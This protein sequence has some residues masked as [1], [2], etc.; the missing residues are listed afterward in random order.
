MNTSEI[1]VLLQMVTGLHLDTEAVTTIEK[2]TEGWTV[3]VQLAALSLRNARDPRS[4]LQAFRGNHRFVLDY[5]SEEVFLQQPEPIQEFL[6]ST[7]ILDR[8]Q[9]EL[10]NAMTGLDNGQTMLE[11]LEKANLFVVSLDE[12]REWYRYHQLFAEVLRIRLRQ[13]QPERL[14][15]LHERASQWYEQQGFAV[16]AIQH[17]VHARNEK[18]VVALLETHGLICL[19]TQEIPGLV[20][21]WL[22][23]LPDTLIQAQPHLCLLKA[24]TYTY[25]SR[26]DMALLWLQHAQTGMQT[27]QPAEQRPLLHARIVVCNALIQ[28]AFGEAAQSAA[29]AKEALELLPETETILRSHMTQYA[30]RGYR[31]NGDVS[32]AT[33]RLAVNAV[34]AARA[35]NTQT[36]LLLSMNNLAWIQVLRGRFHQAAATYREIA[37]ILA[38][39]GHKPLLVGGPSYYICSGFLLREW[40]QLDLAHE[41]YLRN[42][43]FACSR[44]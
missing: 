40:N 15:L 26:T 22:Q 43:H 17:A 21:E 34:V 16:E 12:T 25:L 39:Q 1:Q 31:T 32:T 38:E 41:K 9:S 44:I 37:Q 19:F 6:L 24:L 2:R 30:I 8:L 4:F 42:T 35:S 23:T 14:S 27:Y 36:I 33:E 18:R 3:G 28:F 10:C 7:C 11:T 29:Y 5:L 20:L 13:G